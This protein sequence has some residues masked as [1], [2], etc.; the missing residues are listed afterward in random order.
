MTSFFSKSVSFFATLLLTG[1]FALSAQAF[2]LPSGVTAGNSVE[3][4]TEYTLSNGLRVLLTP[5][6]SRPTTMVNMT[7][8]VGSR[9]ENYGQTG[10]AHLLEHMLFRGTPTLHNALAEFSKRGL[11]ANGSTS[12]DRTNYYAS[13]AADPATLDWY[14][15]WQADAMINSLIAKEDLDSEMTVVRNEMERGENSPFQMLLQKMQAAAYQWHNYGH[16]TIGARSDVENVDIGQLR[17]FYKEYY[18]P[19]NAVL[20]VSGHFDPAATLQTIAQA[21][22]KIP[23]PE[24]TLPP[25]YTVEP[26]QDGERQVIL[27]RHGGSPL[28]GALFHIPSAGSPD[29]VAMDLGVSILSDTPS[30]RL[31]HALVD[32]DL[33]AEVFGFAQGMRQPGYAFF[34]A[35][36]EPGMNQDLALK[37]L[38]STLDSLSAQPFTQAELDRQQ[39]KWLTNWEQ[40]YA[41][42]IGLSN[43]FSEAVADG[44]WRLF[45]SQRDQVK[46]ITLDHVQKTM[47]AYLVPSN[48]TDGLYI[49]TDKPVRAPQSQK[50]DLQALLKNYQGKAAPSEVTAF[51]PTP[52]NIDASTL[53]APLSLSNGTVKLALLP[54]PTRGDRVEAK[55]LIQFANADLLKGQATVS[56]VTAALLNRGTPSLSRQEIQDK[57]DKLQANVSFGGSAGNVMVDMSTTKTYLP[58]LVDLVLDIVRHAD[59]PAKELAEYQRQASTSIKNAMSEPSALASKALARHNNPW[60]SDDIRYTPTFEES[61]SRIASITQQ[62]LVNFHKKFY[63]AGSIEFSAVG[64]FDPDAIKKSL[65][66]GL[67]DWSKAPAYQ[68]IP[69]PY[70]AVEAKHL[71]IDTPDKANAFYLASVPVKLQDTDPLYPALYLAN[72]LL[73]GSE[74][75]RLWTRIRVED[76]ISYNV[77][78]RL[79]LSS[80][81][82]SGDWTLYAILAPQNSQR[83][84]TAMREELERALRDGFSEKEVKDGIRALL[85]YRKLARARDG[86]LASAWINYMQLGR[87]FEWSEKIDRALAA[88]STD[89]VNAALRATLKPADF[90]SALAA[91]VKKETKAAESNAEKPEST[92]AHQI[93]TKPSSVTSNAPLN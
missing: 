31:Y 92:T 45:F 27:R 7:Y 83:L 17:A 56:S 1:L 52:A 57:F 35:Q 12:S 69:D 11:E 41:D 44:D 61:L 30:G 16:S 79:E 67:Q 88:L 84:Q 93:D 6:E 9:N 37:T 73:G 48:R 38:N 59:F 85:N 36:L 34:G 71:A 55:L 60:P 28:I 87:S 51:D 25:E 20:I 33:S 2:E 23:R 19:D 62:D 29:Y 43:V 65:S 53:Q 10:M 82:P 72:Y 91:D 70:H 63:G 74:T 80:Y 89:D 32:K 47:Q 64:A 13:F 81:E 14:I 54:K 76:G 3:G 68:R 15:K 58:A 42:P 46:N 50:T 18:Q 49:P 24:R 40:T 66:Q 8:L 22:G 75:S 90:S 39:S 5:D 86:V 77:R 4:T 78:S 26:V 21:F